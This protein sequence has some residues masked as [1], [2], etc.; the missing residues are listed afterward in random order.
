MKY[1]EIKV[2]VLGIFVTIVG[3]E[4]VMSPKR[5]Y[6]HENTNITRQKNIWIA[7][8][9]SKPDSNQEVF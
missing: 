8:F 2:V 3:I 7:K 1:R 6:V 5:L 4:V 9:K